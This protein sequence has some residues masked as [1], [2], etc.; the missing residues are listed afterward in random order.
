MDVLSE[1]IELEKRRVA[2]GEEL[3]IV[4]AGPNGQGLISTKPSLC[5]QIVAPYPPAGT[6]RTLAR[7]TSAYSSRAATSRG[8]SSSA[9]A[10]NRARR[11]GAQRQPRPSPI[12]RPTR[13]WW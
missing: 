7:A 1:R 6:A 4:I 8:I 5:A 9:R 3:G 2:L 13:R 11:L 12:N 10:P